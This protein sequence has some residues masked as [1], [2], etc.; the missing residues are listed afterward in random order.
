MR[1]YLLPIITSSFVAFTTLPLGAATFT[2]ESEQFQPG[3][4]M[5]QS[6]IYQG[7]GCKGDNMSPQLS[8]HNAPKGT[9][10][11]VVTLFDPDAPTGVGWWH[12][13]VFN[14]PATIEGL[15]L[16]A[17]SSP[18]LPPGSIQGYTDFGTQGYGG[19]C[20]PL[21]DKPHNY[22][23]SVYALD[24]AQIPADQTTTGAKLAFLIKDHIL[25]KATI[26]T[27]YGR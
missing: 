11:Y 24:V 14:I 18:K 3:E 8:W 25:A 22:I 23:L 13:I 21:G 26:T 20:P 12:W 27:K 15:A 17:G 10:S 5:P 9:K 6:I 1:P 2:V 7:F 16:D 4:T 19:A